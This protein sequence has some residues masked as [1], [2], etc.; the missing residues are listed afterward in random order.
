MN[1]LAVSAPSN[2]KSTPLTVR[3]CTAQETKWFDTQM[4]QHH[5]LGAGRPVGD[6]PRQVVECHRQAVALLVWGPACYA[7]KDRDLWLGWSAPQRVQ[8]LKLIVQNRR[9]LLLTPK[10]QAHL[11]NAGRAPGGDLAGRRDIAELARFA[12]TLTQPQRRRLGLPLK[13]GTRALHQVPSYSVFYQALRHMDSE[14]FAQRL[15]QWLQQQASHL[16]QALALDSKMLRNHIGLLTLAQ[17][18]DGAPQA[19]AIYDQKQGAARCELRAA[20]ALLE[21]LPALDGKLISGDA[22]QWERQLAR[23]V[24]ERGGDDLNQVKGDQRRL[25]AQARALDR[26]PPTPFLKTPK[27][28]TGASRCAASTPSPS[29]PCGPISRLP[30]A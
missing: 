13:R 25:R 1:E 27:P 10:G 12:T 9:F 4:G 29:S 26:L 6:Y 16:P 5:Y 2:S 14:A 7:L 11:A 30:A 24:V 3:V 21:R 23:A 17:H 8:R 20:T 18:E 15:T 19:I 22:Q 28:D